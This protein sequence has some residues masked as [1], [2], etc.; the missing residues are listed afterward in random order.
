[1]LA[2]PP[3][4]ADVPRGRTGFVWRRSRF[5][6]SRPTGTDPLRSYAA[7]RTLLAVDPAMRGP[8]FAFHVERRHPEGAV[9][10][11][12]G[13]IP[14]VGLNRWS[15]CRHTDESTRVT[16]AGPRSP[17]ASRPTL[18]PFNPMSTWPRVDSVSRETRSAGSPLNPPERSTFSPRRASWSTPGTDITGARRLPHWPHEHGTGLSN[19][20]RSHRPAEVGT[21]STRT[22]CLHA[23]H[24]CVSRETGT[25]VGLS[26]PGPWTENPGSG[27]R[28]WGSSTPRTNTTH[29]PP[30]H[31]P[32]STSHR[33]TSRPP[34]TTPLG[35][36]P[37]L[38][39]P[40]TSPAMIRTRSAPKRAVGARPSY[41]PDPGDPS[42]AL[43]IRTI[44]RC[45][46]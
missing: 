8:V 39:P 44:S 7:H 42:P 11:E 25:R 10:R 3:M 9:S 1:M 6:A 14:R 12:T 28:G 46:T 34:A 30:V 41:N 24:E 17:S 40:V 16:A 5:R 36:S 43:T 29:Q 21:W 20:S 33:N 2:W 22:A 35:F 18:D 4:D 26:L 23:C 32:G 37:G 31:E 38:Q 45:F 27:G 19:L 13:N 15:P